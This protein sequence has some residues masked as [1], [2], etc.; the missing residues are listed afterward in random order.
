MR[1]RLR[2]YARYGSGLPDR[3]GWLAG[4]SDPYVKVT[5]YRQ[6]GG[7]STLRTGH[8]Q[9]D[10]SPEWYQWLDFGVDSWIRFAVKVYDRDPGS[11]D[12]LSSTTTYYLNG[13]VSRT[14][15]RKNC[16]SGYIIFDYQYQP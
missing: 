6:S 14:N 15:V 2:I 12:S 16:D 8:D 4:D 10:E 9:G 5:A 3:D 1:G 11:D 7:S 13:H